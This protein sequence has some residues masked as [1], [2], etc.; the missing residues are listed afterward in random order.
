MKLLISILAV[1]LLSGCASQRVA[2]GRSS[3]ALP[4]GLAALAMQSEDARASTTQT[5]ES[6]TVVR[7]N[8]TGQTNL[9]ETVTRQ[10]VVTVIGAANKN[11]AQEIAAKLASF[12]WLQ[13]LGVAVALF[14]VASLVYPPLRLIVAS[15]TT[16]AACIASGAG[17]MFAPVLIVGH[18]VEILVACGGAAALWFIAHRH[19]SIRGELAALKN[20]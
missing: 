2:P 10:K 4:G 5:V 17:L 7:A 18:E 13:W 8:P 11:T 14:G 1:C 12:R 19:G 16:S 6:E 15:A 20:Q 9:V 3:V